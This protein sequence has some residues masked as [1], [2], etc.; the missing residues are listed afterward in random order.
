VTNLPAARPPADSPPESLHQHAFEH[1]QFIRETMERAGAFTAVSGAGQIIVGG[2]GLLA[3]AIAG[4]V[5]SADGVVA[6][7]VAA[8]V[9]GGGIGLAAMA[10]K[11]RR[12]NVP[13]LSAPGRKFAL[14]FLPPL[15]AAALL[16]AA[17]WRAGLHAWLPGVWLLLFG[18]AVTS[19]GVASV[20]AVPAM[21]TCFM[22][23]GACALFGPPAWGN[24]LMAAGFGGLLVVFGILIAVK[25]GG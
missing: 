23:L 10:R 3:A 16:T 9:V 21:G 5:D 25:Y 15:A 12:A 20:K 14:G 7:W 19:G 11:A 6:V 13:L 24:W 4:R 17:M 2:V 1:L 8:A 18:A 22:A